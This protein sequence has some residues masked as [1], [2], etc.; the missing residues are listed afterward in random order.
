MLIRKIMKILLQYHIKWNIC[1][2]KIIVK[3]TLKG[4][5]RSLPADTRGMRSDVGNWD[6]LFSVHGPPGDL[7]FIYLVHCVSNKQVRHGRDVGKELSQ[8]SQLKQTSMSM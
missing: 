8:Y 7:F 2:W 6:Y 1:V 4:E 3:I 5:T